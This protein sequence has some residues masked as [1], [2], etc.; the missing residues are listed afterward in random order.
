MT[1][2]S[3]QFVERLWLLEAESAWEPQDVK[4]NHG[5]HAV[6]RRYLNQVLDALTRAFPEIDAAYAAISGV[7]PGAFQP[8]AAIGRRPDDIASSRQDLPNTIVAQLLAE[9]STETVL[10]FDNPGEHPL[11][12]GDPRNKIKIIVKLI[13]YGELFGFIS[14]DSYAE[15]GF[16][17]PFLEEMRFLQPPLSRVLAE[18]TFSMR[19]WEVAISNERSATDQTLQSLLSKITNQALLAFAACGAVVRLYD[20]DTDKLPVIEFAHGK[21]VDAPLIEGLIE[22][23]STGETV[24]RRV[25][26]DPEHYWTVGMLDEKRDPFFSGTRISPDEEIR[27]RD[28][29]IHAYCVFRLQSEQAE[30]EECS[31]IGTL[32]FFHRHRR[33]FS[34]RDIALA[35]YLSRSAADRITLYQQTEKLK[36]ATDRLSAANADL[37]Q[38][39]E[40]L[41]LESRM[42]TRVE[43]VSL[44]AHDLGHKALTVRSTFERCS[45]DVKK[46][47]RDGRPF[48]SLQS[49]LTSVEDAITAITQGLRN[50][51]QLFQ[52][53]A[54][55]STRSTGFDLKGVVDELI[56]T[57][58]DALERNNC[59]EQID[60][61]NK[62]TL[63][64]T[65][66]ILLQALFNLM[67]N[68]LEAQ[69]TRKNPRKNTIHIAAELETTGGAP[70][71]A[72]IKFWDEGPGINQSIFPDPNKIFELGRSSKP[73]GTGRG[74]PIARNLLNAYFGADLVLTDPSTARFRISI[75]LRMQQ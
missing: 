14:L 11:F 56:G 62:I 36:E 6:L 32:S 73:E 53:D 17:R 29:G 16:P 3:E 34:W 5:G 1:S 35:K 68:A 23:H 67:I 8:I 72:V 59:Q 10:Y 20:P 43:V 49:S 45:N 2:R 60:I 58:R 24:A 75:P 46:V 52:H 63:Y 21:N 33:R 47:I 4:S 7:V 42:M 55:S 26:D 64:G 70:S 37:E 48:N 41:L 69:R 25:F 38:A 71:R 51:N 12:C 19:L 44:L 39:R 18:S 57:M 74:L 50:V 66:S 27:L 13:G 30:C 15:D 31:K 61:P 65:R 40:S 28:L 9:E 22:D 54:E